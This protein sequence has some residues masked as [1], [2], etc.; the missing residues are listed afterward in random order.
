MNKKIKDKFSEFRQDIV[1]GDWILVASKKRRSRPYFFNQSDKKAKGK[2]TRESCPF[3]NPQKFGNSEP[4]LWYAFEPLKNRAAEFKNWFVQVIPNKYPV[5]VPSKTC[6]EARPVGPSSKMEGVGYHEIIITRPHSRSLSEMSQAEVQLVLKAYQKRYL[7]LKEEK[8]VEYILIFH[9]HGLKAGASI[10]HPHSQ[11]AAM[12]IVPP[13]V[14]RSLNGSK[15]YFKERGRCVHCALLE[16]ELKEKERVIFQNDYFAVIAPFASRVSYE[17][18]IYPKWH[19]SRFEEID[20]KKRSR[21]AEALIE[22]L[23]RLGKALGNPDYN[24]FI[25]TAPAKK[26]DTEYYHWHFEILPKTAVWAGLELG[27]GVVVISISSPEEAAEK[28][29][30]AKNA[31]KF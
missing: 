26:E 10:S 23:R 17:M 13:D 1:S 25:H 3:E 29:K 8:C 2:I 14:S 20:D 22:T 15:K 24:F 30:K 21:L 27:T 7:Q 4:V 5:V 11:L 19:T 16:W 18:R 6:P 9:N 28:L 12:P 31:G